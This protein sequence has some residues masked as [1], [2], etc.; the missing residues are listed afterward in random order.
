MSRHRNNIHNGVYMY[1][2]RMATRAHT[3]VDPIRSN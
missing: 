3:F 1:D 2:E